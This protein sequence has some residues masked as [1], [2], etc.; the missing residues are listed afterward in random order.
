MS[1]VE[2]NKAWLL[3]LLG[4]GVGAVVYLNLRTL[5]PTAPL[6]VA[7]LTLTPPPAPGGSAPTLGRP[8]MGGPSV[9]VSGVSVSAPAGAAGDLWSDLQALAKAPDALL[10]EEALRTRCRENLG[11]FLE[12][13]AP[14]RLPRPGRVRE[15]ESDKPA[16]QAVQ[17]VQGPPPPPPVPPPVDFVLSGP[18]GATA[19]IHGQSCR[20]GEAVA[21]SPY[22]VASIEWN[23]VGLRGPGGRITFQFTHPSNHP[24]AGTRPSSE[25]P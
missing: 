10:Q 14:V 16:A 13:P 1:F 8:A 23:R 5:S 11:A 6:P 18:R 20:V 9:S 17:A 7:P 21:G 12:A 15:A 22:A 24:L 4:L 3:P 19:W 2:K 25:A